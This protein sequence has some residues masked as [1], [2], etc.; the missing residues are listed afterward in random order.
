MNEPEME[1]VPVS[2]YTFWHPLESIV[3]PETVRNALDV[4][5]LGFILLW[6]NLTPSPDVPRYIPISLVDVGEMRTWSRLKNEDAELFPKNTTD[7]PPELS[8][9]SSWLNCTI[10]PFPNT[11]FTR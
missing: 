6:C 3:V 2:E 10:P 1:L 5:P 9:I 4:E 11:I 8:M 7:V